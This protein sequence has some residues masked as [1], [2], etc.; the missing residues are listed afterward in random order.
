IAVIAAELVG[1]ETVQNVA[2]TAEARNEFI[3][4]Q[5]AAAA[6]IDGRTGIQRHGT[7]AEVENGLGRCSKLPRTGWRE[8]PFGLVC[9]RSVG[10]GQP[11]GGNRRDASGE[12]LDGIRNRRKPSVIWSEVER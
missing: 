6:Q 12:R 7:S 1:V 4:V 2:R 5:V 10:N 11:G 8:I 3:S 9:C